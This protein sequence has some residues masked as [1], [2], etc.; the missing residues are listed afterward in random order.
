MLNLDLFDKNNMLSIEIANCLD[1]LLV[2]MALTEKFIEFI[3]Q[4]SLTV[5][6][7]NLNS[8]F[9]VNLVKLGQAN[10]LKL[11]Q[12]ILAKFNFNLPET[13]FLRQVELSLQQNSVVLARTITALESDFWRDILHCGTNSLGSIIFDPKLALTRSEFIFSKIKLD[14]NILIA[15]SSIFQHKNDIMLLTE[16]FLPDLAKFL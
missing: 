5:G 11:E 13:I 14:N 8:D 9:A 12:Q 10:M 2:D 1:D 4:Q 3:K 16:V 6:L 15:R 7:L